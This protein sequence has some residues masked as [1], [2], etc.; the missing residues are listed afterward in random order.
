Y[1]PV[2]AR[3]R[4]KT[5]GIVVAKPAGRHDSPAM[6]RRPY[7]CTDAKLQLSPKTPL[8]ATTFLRAPDSL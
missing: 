1:L 8:L 4:A 6:A 7:L 5:G 2:P 3:R